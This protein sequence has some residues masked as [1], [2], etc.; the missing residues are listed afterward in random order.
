MVALLKLLQLWPQGAGQGSY[1]SRD[2]NKAR[3]AKKAEGDNN[4]SKLAREQQG[5]EQAS[6]VG[7]GD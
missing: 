5:A 2:E 4:N 7:W 1:C 3:R 6:K